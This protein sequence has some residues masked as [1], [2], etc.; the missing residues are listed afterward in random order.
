MSMIPQYVIVKKQSPYTF[1]RI[2]PTLE[3]AKG[4]A[5]K[6]ARKER[7]SFMV[8]M[9]VAE[10]RPIEIPLQ[11]DQVEGLTGDD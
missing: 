10:V 4:E 3:A 2:H 5:E 1:S 9:I 6:L 7:V 8:L 11:W